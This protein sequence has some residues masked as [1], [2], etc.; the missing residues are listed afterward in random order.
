[1]NESLYRK[2]L[3]MVGSDNENESQSAVRRLKE[4]LIADGSSW[5]EFVADLSLVGEVEFEKPASDEELAEIARKA[6]AKAAQEEVL[7][8]ANDAAIDKLRQTTKHRESAPRSSQELKNA[9]MSK[10]NS[11]FK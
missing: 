1:M 8:R 10:F 7:N 9:N 4:T 6:A 11:Q 3:F 2:L 5:N